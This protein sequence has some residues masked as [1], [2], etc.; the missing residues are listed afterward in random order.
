[1]P[2]ARGSR[3]ALKNRA[4]ACD[5]PKQQRAYPTNNHR[6][7][8]AKTKR[9]IDHDLISG[10]K[11]SSRDPEAIKSFKRQFITIGKNDP[12]H[13]TDRNDKSKRPADGNDNSQ[14]FTDGA[15]N[16]RLHHRGKP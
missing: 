6:S 11:F 2:K 9:T 4:K 3:G 15:D 8:E 7:E 14:Q 13:P 12:K 16:H 5:R 1:M 10:F